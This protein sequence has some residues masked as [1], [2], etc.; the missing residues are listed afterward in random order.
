MKN[1]PKTVETK[2]F[3]YYFNL[4]NENEAKAYH[5][6][7]AKMHKQKNVCFSSIGTDASKWYKET[8]KPLHGQTI[9]LETEFI[10]GNQWNTGPTKTSEQGLRVFDWAETIYPNRNI[11]EGQYLIITP[12]MQKIR[13][14]WHRCAWCGKTILKS[15]GETCKGKCTKAMEKHIQNK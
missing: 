11:K 7:C 4:N 3:Y 9:R 1:L 15:I 2:L 10:F 12:E 8:I 14:T 6:L 13:L 5:D